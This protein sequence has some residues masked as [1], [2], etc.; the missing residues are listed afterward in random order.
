M[1]AAILKFNS[2]GYSVIILFDFLKIAFFATLVSW[3]S[4]FP[5]PIQG[6]YAI[7]ARV[8]LGLFFLL[9]FFKEGRP[10]NLFGFHDWPLWV[11]LASLSAGLVSAQD[12]QIAW[13]TYFN[14]VFNLF[15]IFYIGKV[16][17]SEEKNRAWIASVICISSGLVA[18][19]GISELY[20][21]KSIIY[22]SFINNPFYVRYMGS[23]PMSTQFNPAVLGSYLLGCLPFSFY[24]SKDKRLYL[25]L[26]GFFFSLSVLF[27]IILTFS[28]GVFLGLI[29]LLSFYLWKRQKKTILT[30][31]LLCLILFVSVCSFQKNINLNRLGFER[32]ILGSHDSMISEYRLNRVKMALTIAKDYPFFGIGFNHFRIRFDEYCADRDKG[33]ELYEFRIPDNM[34]LTFLAE[35]GIVGTLGFLVFIFLLFKKAFRKISEIKNNEKRHFL[36]ISMSALIGLLVNMGAYE[37][38]YWY[39]PYMLFCLFC[40][41]MGSDEK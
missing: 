14:L 13:D 41:F 34:Y 3:I 1:K 19:I 25:R 35:T 21:G 24:L 40:G 5:E 6:K 20:F 4:F 38:F 10:K 18:G 39:N 28:R 11:F 32:L 33:E 2:I 16:L 7:Y 26:L 15:F 12:K 29:A 23:R 36:V 27:V 17:L 30:L 37:L 9:L 22:E 31:F 8:F